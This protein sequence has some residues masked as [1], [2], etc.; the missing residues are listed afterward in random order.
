[1][2]QQPAHTRTHVGRFQRSP[3]SPGTISGNP[4]QSGD[5]FTYFSEV[6][7]LFLAKNGHLFLSFPSYA[8][9]LAAWL[10]ASVGSV[11]GGNAA[12]KVRSRT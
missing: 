2:S 7:Q 11:A 10:K 12:K 6:D 8:N 9:Q 3:T 1:M 4:A 5:L